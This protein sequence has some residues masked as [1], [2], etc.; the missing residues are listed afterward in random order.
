MLDATMQDILD[1][2]ASGK[3]PLAQD[4]TADEIKHLVRALFQN[5]DHRAAVLVKIK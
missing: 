2:W 4:F 5:T 3:G 1:R